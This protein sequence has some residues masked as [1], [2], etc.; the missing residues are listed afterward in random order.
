MELWFN[1][2]C[3]SI[4]S[5]VHKDRVRIREIQDK[6]RCVLMEEWDP[7][8]IHDAPEGATDEYDRYIGGIYGLIQR[9]SSASEISAHLRRLEVDEMGMVNAQGLPFLA[10][11]KR[12]EIATSLLKLFSK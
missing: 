2:R 3:V 8:G 10:D 11:G 1:P 4:G 9:G 12:D 7:I 6:I 5:M